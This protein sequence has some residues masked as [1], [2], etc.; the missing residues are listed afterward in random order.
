[1]QKMRTKFPRLATSGRHDSAMITDRRN[2]LPDWLSTRCL[3]SI[4]AIR[5]NSVFPI[6]CTFHTRKVPTQIFGNVRSLRC[7]ILRIKTNS[8]LKFWWAWR[9]I[10][11]KMRRLNW[12][13]KI[14]NATQRWYDSVEARDTRHRRMQEVNSLCTDSGPLQANHHHHLRLF[15]TVV[16]RNCKKS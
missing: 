4:F 8:T 9:P 11:K 3:L 7:P 12:K 2:S 10:W 15:R 5:I 14:S 6:R 16:H 13:L 1:M